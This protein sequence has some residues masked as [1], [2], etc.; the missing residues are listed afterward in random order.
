M[1]VMRIR[2]IMHIMHIML[3]MYIMLIMHIDSLTLFF[4]Y[5]QKAPVVFPYSN[6]RGNIMETE[7]N[8]CIKHAPKDIV[9]WADSINMSCER[10]TKI[11]STSKVQRQIK[12]QLL[13]YPWHST[14][15]ER[16][17]VRCCVKQFKVHF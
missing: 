13:L 14:Q 11:G 4:R 5:L 3:I 8:H 16:K 17:P 1:D 15:F 6:S 2:H 9:K 12:V 10:S 7:K